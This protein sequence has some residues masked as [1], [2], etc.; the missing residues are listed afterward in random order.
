[1]EVISL[2]AAAAFCLCGLIASCGPLPRGAGLQSEVLAATR[3]DPGTDPVYDFAVFEIKRDVLP[4]LANWPQRDTSHYHWI[5]HQ[6]QPASLII[7]PGDELQIA[8]WD[9]EEN[10]L[11]TGAG[12]RV[13]QLQNI[14]VNSDGRIFIP[15]VGDLRVAGM[16]PQ[17][18]RARIET[19]LAQSQTARTAQIQLSVTPGRANTA[20]LVGGVAMPGV[21]P[22]PD[23][24]YSLLS[25]LSKGGGVQGGLNNP[26]VRL[27]R[28][29]KVYGIA[30]DRLYDDPQLDTVLMGGDRVLVEEDDR[31]FL[32]LGATGTEAIHK[33]T[34]EQVSALEALS[35]VGGV[36]DTR[37]NPQGILI[38]RE[39][40]PAAVRSSITAGPP[41]TRVVFAIDLT[42]ADGL[43]SA[44]KFNVQSGDL[45]YATESPVISARTVFGL[46]GTVLGL[47]RQL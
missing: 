29:S 2:R 35:I 45:V 9:A 23:R 18:A 5:K 3:N 21:Y 34:R 24:N 46:L 14:K 25:L 42:T 13:A 19:E 17:T 37:A 22:L 1:M 43:F 44:A 10:S 36:S 6:A 12:Q 15:F 41:Q 38:L 30:V 47:S 4:T 32:S 40:T 28:G 8:I 7:A 27:M 20:D 33:F 16:S 31:Y 11:L 39:Y 26:Q